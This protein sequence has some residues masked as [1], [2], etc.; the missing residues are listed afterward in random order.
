LVEL[1]VAIAIFVTVMASVALVFN[2]AIRTSKQGFQNQEAYELARGTMKVLERD[3]SR[4]FTNRDHGDNFS[5]Y[6]T[7][8]GFTLVGLISADESPNPN[9]SR[10]TYVIYHLMPTVDNLAGAVGQYESKEAAMVSTYYL[11]RYIET[12]AD[13]LDSFPVPWSEPST[14]DTTAETWEVLVG[15]VIASSNIVCPDAGCDELLKQSARREVWIR[16]LAGGDAE[17]PS[18]WDTFL[19]GLNPADYV[20]G[21]NI[22]YL[23]VQT[24]DTATNEPYCA[25]TQADLE[26]LLEGLNLSIGFDDAVYQSGSQTCVRFLSSSAAGPIFDESWRAVYSAT[27]GPRPFFTYWDMGV[28]TNNPDPSLNG[29]VTPVAFQFWNDWRNLVADGLDNNG[30]LLVDEDDERYGENSGSPL[31]TRL[32]IAVTTDFTLFFRSPYVGAPD[33]NERFTQR[34]DLPVGYRRSFKAPASAP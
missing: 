4:A 15:Q 24:T 26:A 22:R 31:D 3:L 10:V 23:T 17:I 20:V 1:L 13:T 25:A 2:T 16:A 19:G 34:I 33:F 14:T 7:P 30:D 8:I 6:G 9:M 11:L 29:K 12:N 32:P 18:A 27:D 5:F 21:E 28:I